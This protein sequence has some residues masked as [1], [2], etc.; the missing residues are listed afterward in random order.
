MCQQA[1]RDGRAAPPTL[2]GPQRYGSLR[3]TAR[4]PLTT[5]PWISQSACTEP[6]PGLPFNPLLTDK[7]HPV[8]FGAGAGPL[9]DL[10]AQL[11]QTTRTGFVQSEKTCTSLH[12]PFGK[13]FPPSLL[14]LQ[15]QSD[16]PRAIAP[17]RWPHG[18]GPRAMAPRQW[19]HGDGP[20]AMAPQ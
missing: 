12:K 10:R 3:E 5:L 13:R 6:G 11:G 8:Y 18:D 20:G 15:P 2:H 1:E 9:A 7:S 14:V 4:C 16:G 19:P 17:R